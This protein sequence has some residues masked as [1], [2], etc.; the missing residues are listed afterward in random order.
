MDNVNNLI[1][2]GVRMGIYKII[3]PDGYYYIGS[4]KNVPIRIKSHFN[5]LKNNR[6]H[7][8]LLQR[9]F[10]AHPEWTWSVELIEQIEQEDKL[11]SI[12]QK[13]LDIHCGLQLCVNCNPIAAKPPSRKGKPNP[14]KGVPNFKARGRP[15]PRKGVPNLKARGRPSFKKG[16]SLSLETRAKISAAKAGHIVTV[17]QRVK[18][19]AAMSGRKLAP[20]SLEHKIKIGLANKNRKLTPET[21][22]KRQATRAANRLAKIYNPSNSINQLESLYK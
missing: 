22:A 5:D 15:S 10:N 6:H 19:S 9:K 4:S 11:L 14:R 8:R 7:T 18:Q 17:E 3:A 1:P 16:K 2:E 21:I 20:L 13:Y 12:E